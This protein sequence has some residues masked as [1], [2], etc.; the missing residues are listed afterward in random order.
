MTLKE[1]P[2]KLQG[3]FLLWLQLQSKYFKHVSHQ[4]IVSI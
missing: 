2:S 3:F 4:L 1:E